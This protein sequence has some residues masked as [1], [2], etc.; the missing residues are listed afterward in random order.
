[1]RMF[2]DWVRLPTGWIRE[3]GL[4]ELRWGR[5]GD[6]S[7]FTAGL[8][9]LAAIAHRAEQQSGISHAT[10]DQLC[11]ATSLSRS[12]LS[13][14]LD[15]LCDFKVLQRASDARSTYQLA[16][17]YPQ[18][19]WGKV[20][21]KSMYRG[22]QIVAFSDFSLRRIPELDALKLFF[23]FIAFRDQATNRAHIG[24]EKI[25]EYTGVEGS[26]I[27]TGCSLLVTQSLIQVEYVPRPGNERG[28][29]N[30]YR[31]V[32]IDPYNHLGTRGRSATGGM[33]ISSVGQNYTASP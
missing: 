17:F 6:G 5:G 18:F 9:A 20:P 1:M 28:G 22:D 29:A 21:A 3:R 4:C 30:A 24:Y 2:T 33:P 23:L 19:G 32:G 15:M 14:G 27:K 13:R 25:Q 11:S 8:M 10:Y 31:I 12:K 26:R 7:N 16:G